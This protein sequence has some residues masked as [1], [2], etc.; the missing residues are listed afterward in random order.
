MQFQA[1][2]H[3]VRDAWEWLELAY[4]RGWTDGLPVAPPTEERVGAV[5]DYLGRDPQDVVGIVPPRQGVATVE[6]IAINCVM[7]GCT[8]QLTPA[9]LAAL[10][11]MLRPEFNLNDVQTTTNACAP[12]TIAHSTFVAAPP[13]PRRRV[14]VYPRCLSTSSPHRRAATDPASPPQYSPVASAGSSKR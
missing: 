7:A 3:E 5:L 6:A 2:A 9:V 10:E 1:T 11:A 8:P 13:A 14:S 12:L 4:E